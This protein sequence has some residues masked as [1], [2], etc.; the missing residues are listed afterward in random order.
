[1]SFVGQIA[2]RSVAHLNIF[3]NNC[4]FI[5]ETEIKDDFYILNLPERH[6]RPE[7]ACL[8]HPVGT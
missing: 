6:F 1:M 3:I 5:E 8:R 2:I 7:N 4:D